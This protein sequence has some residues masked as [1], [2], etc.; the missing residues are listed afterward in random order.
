M[1]KSCGHEAIQDQ[2]QLFS[3]NRLRNVANIANVLNQLE[4][5]PDHAFVYDLAQRFEHKIFGNAETVSAYYRCISRKLAKLYEKVGRKLNLVQRYATTAA[6]APDS[7]EPCSITSS[8]GRG[9][10]IGGMNGCTVSTA[11][12]QGNTTLPVVLNYDPVVVPA[13]QWNNVPCQQQETVYRTHS[14]SP[15]MN[16]TQSHMLCSPK[17]SPQTESTAGDHT[18]TKM[19]RLSRTYGKQLGQFIIDGRCLVK[20]IKL[21]ASSQDERFRRLVQIVTLGERTQFYMKY[22]ERGH[23][24][25]QKSVD[26]IKSSLKTIFETHE[27]IR[28]KLRQL[29]RQQRQ[30]LV[31]GSQQS[32]E[33]QEQNQCNTCS[34]KGSQLRYSSMETKQHQPLFDRGDQLMSHRGS[35]PHP[36][37][38]LYQCD[39]TTVP[40]FHHS[41]NAN[42]ALLNSFDG[43]I[44]KGKGS[45]Q[46]DCVS[47]MG[48]YITNGG[49]SSCKFECT[50]HN[51]SP[52]PLDN[53]IEEKRHLEPTPLV[54]YAANPMMPMQQ[55]SAPTSYLST[56]SPE[57][58][59]DWTSGSD[60][61]SDINTA[62]EWVD[63]IRSSSNMS[64]IKTCDCCAVNERG[65]KKH[66]VHT[67][68][69]T[70]ADSN[71]GWLVSRQQNEDNTMSL[72]EELCDTLEE[73]IVAPFEMEK[74]PELHNED[75]SL[76]RSGLEYTEAILKDIH[77]DLPVGS[78]MGGGAALDKSS[79]LDKPR[80]C[81]LK[82]FEVKPISSCTAITTLSPSLM[83]K[84]DQN[85]TEIDFVKVKSNLNEIRAE[86]CLK[87]FDDSEIDMLMGE[88]MESCILR[89]TCHHFFH[90]FI[91][92]SRIQVYAPDVF[93]LYPMDVSVLAFKEY[94]VGCDAADQFLSGETKWS[95]SKTEVYK[96]IS[97][98]ALSVIQELYQRSKMDII[99]TL[100]RFFRWM[101]SYSQLFS[102]PCSVLNRKVC[103]GLHS[104]VP[105]P[106][107]GRTL[108]GEAVYPINDYSIG[109]VNKLPS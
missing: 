31:Q 98:C 69:I 30:H 40:Q 82:L 71:N 11:S 25:S 73:P 70:A 18:Q 75:V 32:H 53:W 81:N 95:Q 104:A 77:Y 58:P 35:P 50:T 62:T 15:L 68:D 91:H 60:F 41:S 51:G 44:E 16:N 29:T 4:D 27:N 109:T 100:K 38:P 13:N 46:N 39:A 87:P 86:L 108:K 3:R 64:E 36:L 61:S 63:D 56:T 96:K 84:T 10:S 37:H 12:A 101:K 42:H 9:K 106:P 34:G 47:N 92:V 94:K 99:K 5:N 103:I 102:D 67:V 78:E 76:S 83:K 14:A 6:D 7:P 33:P 1:T 88:N 20:A 72:L 97:T 85:G 43:S 49:Q 52:S 105:L 8:F 24:P 28:K 2:I 89:A 57:Y 90:I 23:V 65:G 55:P 17:K 21:Q 74:A 26:M 54:E 107:F 59:M 45:S 22:C 66:K 80:P 19:E 48:L 93:S 79:L